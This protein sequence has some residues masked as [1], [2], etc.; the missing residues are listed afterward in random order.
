MEARDRP[1]ASQQTRGPLQILDGDGIHSH[2]FS[3]EGPLHVL[4]GSEGRIPPDFYPPGIETIAYLHFVVDGI[5][6]QCV[7]WAFLSTLGLHK[8][9]QPHIQMGK[10]ERHST[11]PL[12]GRLTS[13]HQ[14]GAPLALT[15]LDV[16]TVVQRFGT[17]CQLGE[18]RPGTYTEGSV[19]G[20][21]VRPSKRGL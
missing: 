9:V 17:R 16:T 18:I 5:I 13:D 8:G 19:S 14:V 15:S 4:T 11:P 7:F 1:F 3:K 6:Y 20:N 21:E 2:R 10:S 12:F